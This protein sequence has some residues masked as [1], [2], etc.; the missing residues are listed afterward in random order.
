MT[1][2]KFNRLYTFILWDP[3]TN[4]NSNPSESYQLSVCEVWLHN[5]TI[6]TNLFDQK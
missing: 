1:S 2:G 4:L 6:H 3:V 5:N